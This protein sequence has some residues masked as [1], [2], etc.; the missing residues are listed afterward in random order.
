MGISDEVGK[1]STYDR[2]KVHKLFS[3]I[4]GE[5]QVLVTLVRFLVEV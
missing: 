3:N 1:V 2:L 5:E 4:V